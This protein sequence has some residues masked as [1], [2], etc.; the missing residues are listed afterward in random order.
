LRYNELPPKP[1]VIAH[2]NHSH[3]W[4]P[5]NS[6]LIPGLVEA[7]VRQGSREELA[8]YMKLKS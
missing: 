2:L 1:Y 4:G 8:T 6:D 5:P 7:Q 3:H